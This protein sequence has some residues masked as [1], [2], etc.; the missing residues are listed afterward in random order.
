MA[1]APSMLE[2]LSR[3]QNPS[4]QEIQGQA[5]ASSKGGVTELKHKGI[6]VACSSRG[7]ENG[8][9]EELCVPMSRR[10]QGYKNA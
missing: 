7:R 2:I 5:E 4:K 3:R 1:A 9:S 6:W 8:Y 10:R